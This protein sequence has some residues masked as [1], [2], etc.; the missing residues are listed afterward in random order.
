MQDDALF[1]FLT[2]HET[3]MYVAEMRLN[4]SVEEKVRKVRKVMKDL[5]LLSISNQR[6]G[7]EEKGGLSRGQKR[8]ITVGI[9]LITSPSKKTYK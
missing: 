9:E 2:V 4:V 6:V 8:R 5:E 7:E 1:P 3:L